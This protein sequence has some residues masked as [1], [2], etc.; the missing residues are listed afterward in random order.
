MSGKRFCALALQ[1]S[2]LA[3]MRIVQLLN[4]HWIFLNCKGLSIIWKYFSESKYFLA[5]NSYFENL[6]SKHLMCFCGNSFYPRSL[7][8]GELIVEGRMSNALRVITNRGILSSNG[9]PFSADNLSGNDM[10]QGDTQWVFHLQILLAELITIIDF[11]CQWAKR[12]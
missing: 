5:T 6:I 10:R 11:F 12:M 3:G 2:N 9:L 1:N 7:T 8:P 4:T